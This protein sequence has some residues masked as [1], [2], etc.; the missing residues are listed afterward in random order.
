MT[1]AIFDAGDLVSSF[2]REDDAREALE[3]LAAVSAGAR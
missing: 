2:D 1:Y 3:H